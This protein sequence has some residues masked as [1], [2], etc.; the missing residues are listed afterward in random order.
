MP[1][2]IPDPSLGLI[3]ATFQSKGGVLLKTFTDALVDLVVGRRPLTDFDAL[4]NDWRSNGG[5]QM[6]IEFQQAYSA[7]A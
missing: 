1:V 4:V 5:D 3:S 6:R 2:I 7:Q